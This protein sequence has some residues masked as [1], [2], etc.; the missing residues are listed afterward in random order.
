MGR[1]FKPCAKEAFAWL[2]LSLILLR[3]GKVNFCYDSRVPKVGGTVPPSITSLTA[4]IIDALQCYLT[5]SLQASVS[6]C[7]HKPPKS[8]QELDS[9]RIR[10]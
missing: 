4:H 5:Q 7:P 6:W 1:L 3:L 8:E 2:G 10:N 9:I